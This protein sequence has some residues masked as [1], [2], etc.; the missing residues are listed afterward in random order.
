MYLTKELEKVQRNFPK[1]LESAIDSAGSIRRL[2]I[3]TNV[4]QHTIAGWLK[5]SMP[6]LENIIKILRYLDDVKG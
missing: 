5:G 6:T 2:S 1:M 3:A 4:R